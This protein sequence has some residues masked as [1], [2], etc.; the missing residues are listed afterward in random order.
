M[1]QEDKCPYRMLSVAGGPCRI[2]IMIT[3]KFC[4]IQ[5]Q[6]EAHDSGDTLS[7][8]K[9]EIEKKHWL[10]SS[11]AC[12][13]VAKT[14]VQNHK[15]CLD[16][17]V[18]N[19]YGF[20]VPMKTVPSWRMKLKHRFRK[21]FTQSS[22]THHFSVLWTIYT[23]GLWTHFETEMTFWRLHTS[24][25]PKTQKWYLY[26]TI[27]LGWDTC[28]SSWTVIIQWVALCDMHII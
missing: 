1:W 13:K 19:T 16:P 17:F 4:F 2:L 20:T 10:I 25:K 5:Q 3:V 11:Q 26:N 15:L 21:V 6:G 14:R 27:V 12:T 9:K 18:W 24:K 22:V 7:H 8:V 23:F 28:R